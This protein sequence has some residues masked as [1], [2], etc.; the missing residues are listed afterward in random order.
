VTVD[1]D[2]VGHR[3]ADRMLIWRQSA[4]IPGMVVAGVT[5]AALRALESG[6]GD[7]LAD[8]QHVACMSSARCQPGLKVRLAVETRVP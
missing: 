1:L 3:L 6:L 8:E 2:D 7:A 5:A 4:F